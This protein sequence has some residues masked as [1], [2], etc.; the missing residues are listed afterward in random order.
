MIDIINETEIEIETTIFQR[1]F[2][3]MK[4]D[5]LFSSDAECC[6]KLCGDEA[7]R[8]LNKLYRGKDNVTD[9]LSF[10]CEIRNI[11]HQGDIVINVEQADRQRGT[12]TLI[13]E[14]SY[15]CIHG[16]LHLAG[17]DHLTKAERERMVYFEEKYRLLV[18]SGE[19]AG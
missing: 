2:D 11:P 1:I 9:V 17:F 19:L 16:L 14:L 3:T 8:S 18:L 5:S 6:L 13:K 15:L 10:C 4:G 7:I 12:A